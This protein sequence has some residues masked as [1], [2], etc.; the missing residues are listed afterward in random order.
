MK[1]VK[2]RCDRC[3]NLIEDWELEIGEGMPSEISYDAYQ[4]GQLVPRPYAVHMKSRCLCT[5]CNVELMKFMGEKIDSRLS[6]SLEILSQRHKQSESD[7]A[8]QD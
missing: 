8:E 4:V 5:S 7:D 2:Y 1:I 6:R 3:G